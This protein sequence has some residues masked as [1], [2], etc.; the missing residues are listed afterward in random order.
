MHVAYN[1]SQEKLPSDVGK[2]WNKQIEFKTS[3]GSLRDQQK[4]AFPLT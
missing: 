4:E 1:K 2:K 3:L